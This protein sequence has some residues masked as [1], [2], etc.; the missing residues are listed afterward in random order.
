MLDRSQSG[1]PETGLE[2][3]EST[4]FR[5][6][7]FH[8]GSNIQPCCPIHIPCRFAGRRRFRIPFCQSWRLVQ[9]SGFS[10]FQR[11]ELNGFRTVPGPALDR[12]RTGPSTG[13]GSQDQSQRTGSQEAGPVPGL[14]LLSGVSSINQKLIMD[15]NHFIP[16]ASHAG[17]LCRR[18]GRE[19]DL[20]ALPRRTMA[21]NVLDALGM[22]IGQVQDCTPE[23]AIDSLICT[24]PIRKE[25]YG[26]EWRR[27]G[28]GQGRLGQGRLGQ[29]LGQ[30][31]GP[32]ALVTAK[33]AAR[34]EPNRAEKSWTGQA[35]R[36]NNS[37]SL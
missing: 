11:A 29:R 16:V 2:R 28:L 4:Y 15:S 23:H 24:N 8:I 27:Q 14:V 22:R 3:F 5:K 36:L 18:L 25:R 34:W 12:S 17:P 1:S 13:P 19:A 10:A 9:T 31:L 35:V 6:H 37:R 30:R 21:Q 33:K 32:G 7:I 26:L 20:R